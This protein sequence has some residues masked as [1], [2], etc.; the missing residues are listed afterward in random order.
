MPTASAIGELRLA[1]GLDG[2]RGVKGAEGV[3]LGVRTC[4]VFV[5]D[6]A[7]ESEDRSSTRSSTEPGALLE[8]EE[9]GVVAW[10]PTVL[11]MRT[12]I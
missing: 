12:T 7:R 1:F 10:E 8:L 9:A 6:V 5:P 4:G 3:F 2:G 11:V